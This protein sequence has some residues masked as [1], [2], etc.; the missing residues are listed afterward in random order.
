MYLLICNNVSHET[1]LV[2]S[3]SECMDGS[4]HILIFIA[5]YCNTYIH[6]IQHISVNAEAMK[7]VPH[8][9]VARSRDGES[10]SKVCLEG[11]EC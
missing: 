5:Y 1:I 4:F 9:N 6:D 8:Q 10:V 7:A 2:I 3:L 11:S